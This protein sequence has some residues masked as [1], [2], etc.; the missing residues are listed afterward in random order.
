MSLKKI[1]IADE[2]TGEVLDIMYTDEEVKDVRNALEGYT[3][4]GISLFDT[5]EDWEEANFNED[6]IK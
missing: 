4:Y 2:A 3:Q 5:K 1:I 6:P